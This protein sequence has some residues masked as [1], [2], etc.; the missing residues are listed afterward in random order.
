MQAHG[1][2]PACFID[3]WLLSA[4][5]IKMERLVFVIFQKNLAPSNA[6]TK[7]EDCSHIIMVTALRVYFFKL[8]L[9]LV[10]VI[11]IHFAFYFTHVKLF[12]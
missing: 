4:Y 9:Y 8:I 3:G 5:E 6:N 7:L 11:N 2:G 10:S 1:F 12:Y